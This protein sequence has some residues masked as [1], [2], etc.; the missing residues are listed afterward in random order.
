MYLLYVQGSQAEGD[1]IE[2]TW[3]REWSNRQDSKMVPGKCWTY[4][5]LNDAALRCT[6]LHLNALHSTVLECTEECCAEV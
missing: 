6:V 4:L 5:S 1:N 2:K 3:W